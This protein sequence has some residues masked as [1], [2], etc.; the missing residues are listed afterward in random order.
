[1]SGNYAVR[2]LSLINREVSHGSPGGLPPAETLTYE[3]FFGLYE[4]PFSLNVDPRF[5]YY[6]P[7]Y[8]ATREKLL[9]GIRRREG[10]QV[11]TGEIGTGKT[12]LCRA[13]LQELGRNT[14]ASLVPDPFASREDLLKTLLVDFG[15]LSI[16]EITTGERRQASRT[17]LGFVL[18][19]FLNSVTAD[20][21]VVVIIDEAQNLS[22]PLIEETRILFDTFGARGRLQIVFAGQPELHGKMKVPEMRQVD[23]RVC[24]YHRLAPMNREAVAGYVQHRLRVAG[25]PQDR[26][27]FPPH[28]IDA[29]H[30]R[31]GGV[32]RLINRI[33]DSA[34][35]IACDR[36]M[37]AVDSYILSTAL[38]EIGAATLSPTW[39]SI[40]FSTPAA[41]IAVA[42]V[43]VTPVAPVVA[44][45]APPAA[46]PAVNKAPVVDAEQHFNKQIDQWVEKD[47]APPPSRSVRP[48]H[49]ALE[50]DA[51][52]L[53]APA[54]PAPAATQRAGAKRAPSSRTIKREWP[55]DVRSETYLRRLSRKVVKGIAIA[56]VA[57]VTLNV[58]VMGISVVGESL[59]P[60]VLPALPD[61]PA[62]A[63]PAVAAPV[64]VDAHL[65]ARR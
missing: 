6:S 9:G 63:L 48:L 52:D 21:H 58:A 5:I 64:P 33:C 41:P 54:P 53:P 7:A 15:V 3:P 62:R 28:V 16:Q 59:T 60:A 49:E 38:M 43:A 61:A 13:A 14:Y 36:Q 55:R 30:L 47:L 37:P 12:T 31:S 25:L 19:E 44:A 34:L 2:P 18:G 20:A 42:P 26:V 65:E 22:L 50:D 27:L 1:M 10:L 45:P 29:L 56:V 57:A 46:V 32:P 4:K 51:F 23:Q 8:V 35:Q 11:L 17:E 24:G 39:D 40:I